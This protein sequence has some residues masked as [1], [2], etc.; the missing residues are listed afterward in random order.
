MNRYGIT[1]TALTAAV[2]LFVGL[3]GGSPAADNSTAPAVATDAAQDRAATRNG[4]VLKTAEDFGFPWP[5]MTLDRA[6]LAVVCTDPQVDFLSEKGV[7]WGVIK[8]TAGE[9]NTVE[10]IERVF[11]ATKDANLPLC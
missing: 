1:V 8:K 6:T 5:G 4:I 9:N 7:A 10:N 11:K 3:R 2:G